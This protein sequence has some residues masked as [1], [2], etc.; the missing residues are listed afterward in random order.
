MKK[1]LKLGLIGCGHIAELVHLEVLARLPDVELTAF[2]DCDAKRPEQFRKRAP[3]AACF[4]DYRQLLQIPE[5]DAAVICLPPALHAEAAVAAFEHGKHVYL[6]K[7]L[8]TNLEAAKDV[9]SAWKKAKRVGMIGFNYR[10]NPLFQQ[11]R[12]H[13]AAESIGALVGARSIFSTAR[14]DLPVW[15]RVRNTGGGVLLELAS[16]HIDLLRFFFQ[17]EV[18]EVQ[19]EI[20]SHANEDDTA[21]LQLELEGG[22][23]AQSFFSFNAVEEDRFEVFGDKGKLTVDRYR[24]SAVEMV[25]SGEEFSPWRRAERVVAQLSGGAYRIRK[26]LASGQELSYRTALGVFVDAVTGGAGAA[27]DLEDGLRALEVIEAAECSS[28]ERRTIGLQF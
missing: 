10:F 18:R 20:R 27:P 25:R 5:L 19:A 17:R 26:A 3:K 23:C 7:P 14:R 24:S 21:W 15:K 9:I 8:A 16:H 13:I 11:L 28:R 2:A 22:L 1:P 4:E 6:E 12:G